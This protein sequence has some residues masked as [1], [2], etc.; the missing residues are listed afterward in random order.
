[1][2]IKILKISLSKMLFV[3]N[4]TSFQLPKDIPTGDVLGL[5]PKNF[6]KYPNLKIDPQGLGFI[7]VNHSYGEIP[8]IYDKDGNYLPR[9][10][11]DVIMKIDEA[12]SLGFFKY[13]TIFQVPKDLLQ[14]FYF[15]IYKGQEELNLS[16]ELLERD[17]VIKKLL[18]KN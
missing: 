14:Y 3:R 5:V 11:P 4:F 12:K 16:L 18:Q 13:I 1:L 6:S 8:F 2:I 17:L 10:H 15:D 7:A 9:N